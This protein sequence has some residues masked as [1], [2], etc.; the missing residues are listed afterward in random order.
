LSRAAH[1]LKS[2][3]ASIGAM[4]LSAVARELEFL[5]KDG[6]L[7][8]AAE[9]LAHAEAAYAQAS[10]AMEALGERRVDRS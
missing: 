6:T 1:T 5:T 4:A 8:G 2:T 3:S 10:A 7:A 9:L